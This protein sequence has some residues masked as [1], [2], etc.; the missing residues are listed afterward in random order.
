MNRVKALMVEASTVT[1]HPKFIT[2][3]SDLICFQL[4]VSY[5]TS[6]TLDCLG[7]YPNN[8]NKVA[9]VHEQAL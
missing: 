2:S 6:K 7:I 5:I 8:V 4:S 9:I 3:F 1:W